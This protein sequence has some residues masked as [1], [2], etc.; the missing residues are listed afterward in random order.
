MGAKSHHPIRDVKL[1]GVHSIRKMGAR[2]GF[3]PLETAWAC[4]EEGERVESMTKKRNR[5]TENETLLL[6]Y[7]IICGIWR[8]LL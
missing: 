5:E 8:A 7:D 3:I 1:Y 4:P 6:V 2:L